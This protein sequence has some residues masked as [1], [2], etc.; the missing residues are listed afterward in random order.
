MCVCA[1]DVMN[2]QCRYACFLPHTEILL[3]RIIL[4]F[5]KKGDMVS[6]MTAYEACKQILDAPNMYIYRTMIDVCGLCGDYVKSRYIYEVIPFNEPLRWKYRS[7]C[8]QN[9]FY[10]VQFTFVCHP[11]FET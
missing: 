9:L 6:V 10:W 3:C 5:G 8:V 11:V 2:M 1:N 4:G 7:A